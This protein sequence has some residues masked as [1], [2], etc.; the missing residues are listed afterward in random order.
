MSLAHDTTDSHEL[1][2]IEQRLNA[3]AQKLASLVK[4][5]G[6]ARQIIEFSGDMRK[7]AL[8]RAMTGFLGEGESAAAADAKARASFNYGEEM[9]RLA[10]ELRSA[11]ETKAEWEATRVLWEST[12]SILSLHK[13]LT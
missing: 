12:R 5:I 8:A 11:E 10:H 1:A 2:A 13:S 9:K 7:A 4:P 6:Q 3:A